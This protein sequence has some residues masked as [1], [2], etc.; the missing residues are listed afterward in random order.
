M[1]QTGSKINVSWGKVSGADRYE[2]YAAYCGKKFAKIPVKVITGSGVTSTVIKKLDGKKLNLK[3]NF[4]VCV[5]AYKTVDGVK[6]MLGKTVTA[7]I[8]GRK[9]T[10]YT[11]VKAIKLKKSKATIKKGKTWEIKATV[12]LVDPSKKML[13]DKHAP[14]FR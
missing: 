5:V 9:N 14:T 4:K 12:V 6:K 11:N 13:S 10:A 2:V 7:H 8:I 3:K 1:S